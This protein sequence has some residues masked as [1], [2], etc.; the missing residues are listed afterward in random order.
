VAVE[1][2][3]P[4]VNPDSFSVQGVGR[5]IDYPPEWYQAN[6]F[7]YLIF[8]QGMFGRFYRNPNQYQAE[9]SQYDKFFNQFKLLRLFT[10]GNYEVRVYQVDPD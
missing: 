10:D 1:S 5:M 9:V 6:K 7:D 4:F 8:G 2:Y 3:A